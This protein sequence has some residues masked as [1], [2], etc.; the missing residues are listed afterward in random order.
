VIDWT[1]DVLKEHIRALNEVD[2]ATVLLAEL[3]RRSQDRYA[4][5]NEKLAEASTLR[6]AEV[7]AFFTRLL[8]G[9]TALLVLTTSAVGFLPIIDPDFKSTAVAIYGGTGILTAI[10]A[11]YVLG[12]ERLVQK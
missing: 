12:Y 6:S 3:N 8:V 10:I 2:T 1:D 7:T 9:A 11:L 5:S 4:A